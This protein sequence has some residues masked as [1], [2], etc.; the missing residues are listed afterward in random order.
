MLN[1]KEK[2]NLLGLCRVKAFRQ[3]HIADELIIPPKIFPLKSKLGRIDIAMQLLQ[4]AERMFALER[5]ALLDFMF[6]REYLHFR[7]SARKLSRGFFLKFKIFF[8]ACVYSVFLFF[9]KH[10]KITYKKTN[11]KIANT[12][13]NHDFNRETKS[14]L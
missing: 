10:T 11:S 4:E 9:L 5:E 13:S 1:D 12:K 3:R 2:Q 7:L 14:K 8:V 6:S